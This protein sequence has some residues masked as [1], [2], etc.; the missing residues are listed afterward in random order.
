[1]LVASVAAAQNID[2]SAG[3]LTHSD[4]QANGSAKFVG[5]DAQLTDGSGGEAGSIFSTHKVCTEAFQT[6]FTYQFV[7]VADGATFTLQSNSPTA[8]GAPGEGL[9]YLFIPNSVAVKFDEYNNAGEGFNSTGLFSG[10]ADPTVPATDV[11]PVNLDNSNIKKISLSYD[12]TTLTETITDTVTLASFTKT[13]TANLPSLIGATSAYVGFTGATGGLASTQDI[14]TWTFTNPPVTV[15]GASVDTPVLWPPDHTMRTVTVNYNTT[16]CTAPTC[17]LSVSSNQPVNGTG[18]GNTSPDWVVVD[19]H[20]V[21]LR[22][23]RAGDLGARIY[24]IAIRC[25]DNVGNVGTSDVTVTVPLD[26]GN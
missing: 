10:G 8:D 4:L 23:E 22:A 15:S 7:G 26:Q 3:F 20:H 12:G 13:Y 18:D 6:T 5:S 1:V 24:T 11:S 9:G 16:G 21:Q 19:A 25:V 17:T 14:K 2:H